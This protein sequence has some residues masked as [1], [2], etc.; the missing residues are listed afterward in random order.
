MPETEKDTVSEGSTADCDVSPG[1][2]TI[3]GDCSN[4]GDAASVSASD[5][6]R[7]GIWAAALEPAALGGGSELSSCMFLGRWV[8]FLALHL[9]WLRPWATAVVSPSCYDFSTHFFK[10]GQLGTTPI[11]G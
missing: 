9:F 1:N 6:A 7:P 3:S 2:G 5:D 8:P 4:D 11:G 10:H